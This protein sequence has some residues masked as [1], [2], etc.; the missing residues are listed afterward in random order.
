[1]WYTGEAATGAHRI[2]YTTS[3][4]GTNWAAPTRSMDFNQETNWDTDQAYAPCVIKDESTYRMW[5]AGFDGSNW[6]MLYATS[7]N[8]ITWNTPVQA[9]NI[10][11]EGTWDVAHVVTCSVIKEDGV[12][13]MWYGAHNGTNM[14]TVFSTSTDGQTWSNPVRV[15]T[16]GQQGTY[17]TVHATS[18]SVINEGDYYRMWYEGHSGTNYRILTTKTGFVD[19]DGSNVGFFGEGLVANAPADAI[20]KLGSARSFD[21]SDDTIYLGD[22]S[23]LESGTSDF[24]YVFW[25]NPDSV[26]S[27]GDIFGKWGGDYERSLIIFLNSDGVLWYLTDADGLSGSSA[28]TTSNALTQA[29]EWYHVA[30]VRSGT[31]GKIYV[32]GQDFTDQ[33]LVVSSVYDSDIDLTI[34]ST[35]GVD[36]FDGILDEVAVYN[37]ALNSSQVMD[38][39]NGS[40]ADLD[41]CSGAVSV[42]EPV[43][44]GSFGLTDTAGNAVS[45]ASANVTLQ[46]RDGATRKVEFDVTGTLDLSG[47]SIVSDTTNTVITGMDTAGGTS[48]TH[49]LFIPDNGGGVFVCPS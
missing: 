25:M 36:V 42:A 8:G 29:N 15:L 43:W 35:T 34:G 32:N 28:V 19:T 38:L 33:A 12:F 40:N 2:L 13:K 7:S 21:G 1:M 30:V 5:Y 46:I 27:R 3:S 6:R 44:S 49:T 4:D 47:V 26:S 16:L 11:V 9:I 37:S 23:S 39:F 22:P 14:R 45:G 24:S 20:G 48:S 18:P 10:G 17:D 31:S 41:Y